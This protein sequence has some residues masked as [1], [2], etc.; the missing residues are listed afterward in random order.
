MWQVRMTRRADR[1]LFASRF[2]QAQR[3]QWRRHVAGAFR[4]RR[5]EPTTTIRRQR[6]M[7]PKA[8]SGRS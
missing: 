3:K 4:S 1:R 6:A 8:S 5:V 7:S 2:L